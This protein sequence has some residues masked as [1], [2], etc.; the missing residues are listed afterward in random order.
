MVRS[1]G[2]QD[3]GSVNNPLW[4]LIQE[5]MDHAKHWYTVRPADI[6]RDSGVSE[7]VLSKWKQKPTLPSFD[8]LVKII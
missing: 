3:S 1:R 8:Q 2:K 6:A 7:Q 4:A 5:Y